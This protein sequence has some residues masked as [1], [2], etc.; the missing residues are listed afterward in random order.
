MAIFATS[1]IL[2]LDTY[3]TF[4]DDLSNILDY[5]F[6]TFFTIE[7]LIKIIAFGFFIDESSYLRESWS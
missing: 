7:A 3:I 2:V 4:D 6:A 1:L 5:T